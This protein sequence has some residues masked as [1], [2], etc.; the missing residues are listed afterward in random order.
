MKLH[1]CIVLVM[2]AGLIGC[3]AQMA[4]KPPAPTAATPEQVAAIRE[5]FRSQNPKVQVGVIAD[6]LAEKNLAAVE[7][8][9][10][11]A[12]HEGDT[13]CFFDRNMDPVVC[14]KVVHLTDSQVHVQYE[15]P[16]A[17]RREPMKGDIAV[18]F[19]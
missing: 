18:A 1:H 9:D 11:A 4:I 16:Q 2:L 12:F 15:K 14:G 10:L 6:V 8:V 19:Q 17:G 7:E 13:V 5:S 3:Q